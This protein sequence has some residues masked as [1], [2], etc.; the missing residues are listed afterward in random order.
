LIDPLAVKIDLSPG[1]VPGFL[2]Q[3][4][5]RVADRGFTGTRFPDNSEDPASVNTQVYPVNRNENGF[6][7]RELDPEVFDI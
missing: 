7:A 2:K 6:A 5:H 4:D 1:N 3:T